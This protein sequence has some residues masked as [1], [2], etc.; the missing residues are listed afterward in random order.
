M[1]NLLS[2]SKT[3]KISL[4]KQGFFEEGNFNVAFALDISGSMQDLYQKGVV[5]E[6]TERLLALGMNLDSNKSI[7]MYLFGQKDY[8]VGDVTQDNIGGYVRREVQDKFRLE[9]GT[10]YAGVMNRI[11]KEYAPNF[12]SESNQ[13]PAG[14]PPRTEGS[15][16][17]GLFG[18]KK[19]Q[20]TPVAP[21]VEKQATHKEKTQGTIV[22]FITDGDNSDKA[23]TRTLIKELSKEGIFWQFVGIGRSS[24]DFLEELDEMS[25][26]YIDNANFF[27]VADLKA[28]SDEDLYNS[29]VSEFPSWVK[30]ARQKGLIL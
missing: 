24:F 3:A 16:L 9:G 21:V 15:F 27:K 6:L 22:F 23:K 14:P 13:P 20:E 28:T 7:E 30:E 5:Q 18:R 10:N 25:D 17:S 8:V 2:L 29:L 4:E 11:A 1:S 26:R 19:A 12:S